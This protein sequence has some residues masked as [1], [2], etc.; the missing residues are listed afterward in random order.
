MGSAGSN[1]TRLSCMRKGWGKAGTAASQCSAP[2]WIAPYH[3][4]LAV[5]SCNAAVHGLGD[6]INPVFYSS[7]ESPFLQYVTRVAL[8]FLCCGV[9]QDRVSKCCHFVILTF[10]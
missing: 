2:S 10:S 1:A 5:K 6:Y 9:S 3:T 4:H 7:F 8:G